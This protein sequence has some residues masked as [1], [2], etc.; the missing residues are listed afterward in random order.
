MLQDK[1]GILDNCGAKPMAGYSADG[2]DSCL[3]AILRI[4]TFQKLVILTFDS[5]K[6]KLL[7]KVVKM[8]KTKEGADPI[9][10]PVYN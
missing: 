6:P 9:K 1:S 8:R 3:P 7:P 2:D 4:S 5:L 10:N